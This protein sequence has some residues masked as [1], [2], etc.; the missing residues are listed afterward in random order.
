MLA[1]GIILWVERSRRPLLSLFLIRSGFPWM[2][3]P[4]LFVCCLVDVL[5]VRYVPGCSEG[6][7]VDF[8]LLSFFFSLSGCFSL[9]W[10]VTSSSLCLLRTLARLGSSHPACSPSPLAFLLSPL[11]RPMQQQK[12]HPRSP[13]TTVVPPQL[14]LTVVSPS[15]PVQQQRLRPWDQRLRPCVGI[16]LY[17]MCRTTVQDS[18]RGCCWSNQLQLEI[19]ASTYLPQ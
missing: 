4:C 11:S 16:S 3:V 5:W 2:H 9:H 7:L 8:V 1:R 10:G 18:S 12:L 6:C 15:A 17:T 19:N 13:S 14:G